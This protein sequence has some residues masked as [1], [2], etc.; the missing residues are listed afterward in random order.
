MA[1]DANM[2]VTYAFRI[3]YK[4]GCYAIDKCPKTMHPD[5]CHLNWYFPVI[6]VV[7]NRVKSISPIA[8]V[9]MANTFLYVCVQRKMLQYPQPTQSDL[10]KMCENYLGDHQFTAKLHSCRLVTFNI[11][12]LIAVLQ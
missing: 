10:Q 9:V 12:N 7:S 1:Y 4:F 2:V 3:D 8:L 11:Q 5:K 6:L